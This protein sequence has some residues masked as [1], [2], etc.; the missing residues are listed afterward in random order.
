MDTKRKV[1]NM[2]M[3]ATRMRRT[4]LTLAAILVLAGAETTAQAAVTV[5]QDGS[6]L[7][8]VGD[9]EDNYVW[10]GTRYEGRVE[11]EVW[12]GDPGP[13]Y[14]YYDVEKVW[15]DMGNGNDDVYAQDRVPLS[16]P[17]V[18]EVCIDTGNGEDYVELD[19]QIDKR[20]TSFDVSTGNGNDTAR[21]VLICGEPVTIDMGNGD[22]LLH[23][24]AHSCDLTVGLGRGDDSISGRVGENDGKIDG[25]RGEDSRS[26]L[27]VDGGSLD[28]INFED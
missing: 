26:G 25:G 10:I 24:R 22:D 21:V 2:V 13:S 15:V 6:N 18:V 16:S 11:V 14:W 8:I 19:R 20:G 17:S 27:T 9:N 4:V 28:V 7:Y 5:T 23:V 12:L 3:S 1:L